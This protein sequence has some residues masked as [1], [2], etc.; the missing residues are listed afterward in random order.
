LDN[1][2]NSWPPASRQSV[3]RIFP[4]FVKSAGFTRT[5]SAA[6]CRVARLN[7]R[8]EA[9]FFEPVIEVGDVFAVAEF[10]ADGIPV[11]NQGLFD[12]WKVASEQDD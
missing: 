4:G 7:L 5:A 10:T 6:A 8:R 9:L 12:D 1:L 3:N 2:V 11:P